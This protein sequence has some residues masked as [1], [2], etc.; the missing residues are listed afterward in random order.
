MSGI[1]FSDQLNQ[2]YGTTSD[3]TQ[4]SNSEESFFSITPSFQTSNSVRHDDPTLLGDKTQHVRFSV[5]NLRS[6]NIENGLAVEERSS[7]PEVIVLSSDEEELPKPKR[8]RPLPSFSSALY[9]HPA[10]EE[11]DVINVLAHS[12]QVHETQSLNDSLEEFEM[13]PPLEYPL[14]KVQSTTPVDER[15]VSL[16][17]HHQGTLIEQSTSIFSQTPNQHQSANNGIYGNLNNAMSDQNNSGATV[18]TPSYWKQDSL[19]NVNSSSTSNSAKS[20]LRSTYW[21][22]KTPTQNQIRESVRNSLADF[23]PKPGSYD[24]FPSLNNHIT[25]TA[26]MAREYFTGTPPPGFL[27]GA[28]VRKTPPS[29]SDSNHTSLPSETGVQRTPVKS[30]SLGH[31]D[32]KMIRL[33]SDDRAVIMG[34]TSYEP[35]SHHWQRAN[36]CEGVL[37]GSGNDYGDRIKGS[38][39]SITNGS[40]VNEHVQQISTNRFADLKAFHQLQSQPS[41]CSTYASLPTNSNFNIAA[42]IFNSLQRTESHVVDDPWMGCGVIGPPARAKVCI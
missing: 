4:P 14:G 20:L 40:R 13:L 23:R 22:G 24:P 16:D 29:N 36:D 12:H 30:L 32:G 41:D 6:S 38:Y 35:V 28:I 18:L 3:C 9:D 2:Q 42:N 39:P 37:I 17:Q 21:D 34:P 31:E 5:H 8:A 25:N 15:P 10:T 19:F 26:R 27:A 33:Q 11:S 7:L 1:T